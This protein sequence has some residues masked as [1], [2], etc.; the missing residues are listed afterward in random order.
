[1]GQRPVAYEVFDGPYEPDPRTGETEKPG[2]D[3]DADALSGTGIRT[4]RIVEQN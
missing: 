4:I 1:M 3:Q 2:P